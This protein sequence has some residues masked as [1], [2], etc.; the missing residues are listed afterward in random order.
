MAIICETERLILREQTE[1]D[2]AAVLRLGSDPLVMRYLGDPAPTNLEEAR[3]ILRDHPIADYH[4]Y[5]FGRWAVV[6]KSTGENIGFAGLK[7]LPEL[8][9][10]DIGYRLLS[11]HWGKGIATEAS[12]PAIAYGFKVLQL[13]RIIGLVDPENVAS[14]NVLKKLG[15][16]FIGT[17]DQ[18]SKPTDKYAIDRR[19]FVRPS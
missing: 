15:L 6:L 13:E 11:E 16:N 5:G 10:V 2:A 12:R 1:D 8:Q 3:A 17:I 9:E 14:V 7:F 4:K 18:H 19:A